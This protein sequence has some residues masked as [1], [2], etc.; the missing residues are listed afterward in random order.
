MSGKPKLRTPLGRLELMADAVHFRG[1]TRS[2]VIPYSEIR[3]VRTTKLPTRKLSIETH[4]EVFKFGG[5]LWRGLGSFV[6]ELN[7]R[8]VQ[9]KI[10]S[11]GRRLSLGDADTDYETTGEAG[12]PGNRA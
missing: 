9:A 3:A 11:Q 10:A 8:R 4:A 7:F 1:I 2:Y 12:E 6:R 5:G